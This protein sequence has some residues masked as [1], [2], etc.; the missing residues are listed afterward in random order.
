[1]SLAKILGIP[2]SKTAEHPVRKKMQ[3][4]EDVKDEDEN[5]IHLDREFRLTEHS[6]YNGYSGNLV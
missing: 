3:D 1:M 2:E 6:I 4:F 5:E